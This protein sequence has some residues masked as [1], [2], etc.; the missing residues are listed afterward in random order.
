MAQF[1]R[2]DSDVLWSLLG[3]TPTDTAGNRYTNIDESTP[4]DTDYV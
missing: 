4:S 2:P 1:A 3:A